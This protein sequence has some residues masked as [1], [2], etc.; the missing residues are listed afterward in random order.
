MDPNHSKS[1]VFSAIQDEQ[2]NSVCIAYD[3][4]YKSVTRYAVS[5]KDN[6][7]STHL[8]KSGSYRLHEYIENKKWAPP[9]PTLVRTQS[10]FNIVPFYIFVPF[11][12][13][14]LY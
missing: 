3:N 1:D 10:Y 13:R 5:Q 7:Q 8:S 11:H 9:S 2:N 14:V 12:M 6:S 4:A